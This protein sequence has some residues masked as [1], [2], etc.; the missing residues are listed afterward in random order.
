VTWREEAPCWPTNWARIERIMHIT[1]DSYCWVPPTPDAGWKRLA[2]GEQVCGALC[3]YHAECDAEGED[4]VGVWA[5]E[6]R[7][8]VRPEHRKGTKVTS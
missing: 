8:M 2:I 5:G 7:G 1:V 6:I 4:K 3:D